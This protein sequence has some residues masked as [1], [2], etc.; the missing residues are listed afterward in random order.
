MKLIKLMNKV[1]IIPLKG[2]NIFPTF[3]GAEIATS[4]LPIPLK[5]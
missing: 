5:T 1:Q 2:S 4:W 3:T